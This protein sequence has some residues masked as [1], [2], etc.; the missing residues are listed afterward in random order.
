MYKL[1]M[2]AFPSWYRANSI[3]AL[4]PFTTVEG[5]REILQK[6]GTEKEFDFSKPSFIGPPIP[7]TT[8]QGVVNVLSDQ[9]HFKVP[10]KSSSNVN[11]P[12]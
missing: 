10:C 8:W 9:E 2:R 5:N 1:L 6:Q 11:I 7:V 3:Y 12:H 4:F